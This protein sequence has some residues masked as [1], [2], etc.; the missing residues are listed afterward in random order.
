MHH[1]L[2]H[3][4]LRQPRLGAL[5]RFLNVS[6][7]LERGQNLLDAAIARKDTAARLA[8]ADMGVHCLPQCSVCLIKGDGDQG[9]FLEAAWK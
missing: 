4:A 3:Q 9:V 1:R 2:T 6:R 7:I 8:Q 5:Q